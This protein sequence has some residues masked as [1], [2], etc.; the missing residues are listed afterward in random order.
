MTSGPFREL[1]VEVPEQ[2][3]LAAVAKAQRDDERSQRR[4][5]RVDRTMRMT[6]LQAIR[7]VL[8]RYLMVRHGW[9][10]AVVTLFEGESQTRLSGLSP[11]GHLQEVVLEDRMLYLECQVAESFAM[12]VDSAVCNQRRCLC[13]PRDLP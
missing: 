1:F 13:V 9:L 11:C 6:D 4:P 7:N 3:L 5:T 12:E 2:L 10:R 8:P